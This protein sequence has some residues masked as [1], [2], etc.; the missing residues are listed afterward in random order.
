MRVSVACMYTRAYTGC[1]AIIYHYLL[2]GI[3][4]TSQISILL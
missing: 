2:D 1:P 4:C 3:R